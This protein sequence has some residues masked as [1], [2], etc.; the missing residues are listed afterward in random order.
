MKNLRKLFLLLF[1]I[2]FA[3]SFV[4]CKD[5]SGDGDDPEPSNPN[6]EVTVESFSVAYDYNLPEKY[7]FLLKDFTDSNN[8]IGTS[9]D[10]VEIVDDN[11]AGFFLGWYDESDER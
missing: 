1:V 9:V 11:L 6:Q 5:K 8:D 2:P 7:D 10:L 3:F 4:S